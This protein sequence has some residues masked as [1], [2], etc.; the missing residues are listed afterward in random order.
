[1]KCL[2]TGASGFVGRRL[3]TEL[4]LRG[5]SVQTI[6]RKPL[7]IAG[8]AS[9][10]VG[11]VN[12]AINFSNVLRD[13]KVVFHLASRVHVLADKPGQSANAYHEANVSLS[14]SLA[15]QAVAAG[16]ARLVFVSTAKVHGDVSSPGRALRETDSFDPGDFYASSKCEAEAVLREITCGSATDLVIVRPPLVYGPG[17]K[18]NFAALVRAVQRNLPMPLGALENHRSLVALDNLVDF[19]ILCGSHPAAAGEVFFVSDVE[20]LSTAELV[21]QIANAAAVT[22]RLV[23]CPEVLL[24]VCG[25]ILGKSA[26]V[27]R[28]CDNLQLDIG[29]AQTMLGWSPPL[30]VAQGMRRAVAK[31]G[32]A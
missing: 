22:P 26:M 8:I 12:A 2:V 4:L 5:H 19:L 29:K 1:M 10:Y 28:L 16:V 15:R 11:P 30:T 18:A 23:R 7:D 31:D 20:D 17:V 32:D 25:A 13:A 6:S 21:R 27:S 24:R 9:A 14:A 3:C